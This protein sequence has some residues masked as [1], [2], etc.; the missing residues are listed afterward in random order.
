MFSKSNNYPFYE[1]KTFKYDEWDIKNPS[2]HSD[3]K[4]VYLVPV[5]S[6]PEKSFSQ[7]SF[8]RAKL[9]L[10]ALFTKVKCSFLKSV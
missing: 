3:F 1:M 2:L 5:K 8:F 6:A 4:N 10:G 9:F 7:N